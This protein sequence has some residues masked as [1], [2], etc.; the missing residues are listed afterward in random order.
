MSVD[1]TYLVEVGALTFSENNGVQGSWVHALPLGSY[2]HPVYG[3][4]DITPERA[5]NFEESVK[6]KVRG[7]DPSINYQHQ[8]D[9]E[10]AGWVKNAESRSD[11]L[12]LFVEWTSMAYQKLKEKAFKYFS[13]EYHDEWKDSQDKVHKD[14][15]FGGALTNR[16]FMKDLVPINLSEATVDTALE[17]VSII[18]GT[19]VED[20]KGGKGVPQELSDEQIK[21]IVDAVAEKVNPKPVTPEVS[22]T[23][24]SDIPEIKELAENNPFVKVLLDQVEQQRAAIDHSQVQL[25]EQTVVSKL[26]EFDRSKI[27]LTPV[28][29]ELVRDLAMG[30]SEAQSES[31][32]KLL[33][34]MRKGSSFLVE[35]GER[36]GA[37]VNYGSP[38]SAKVQFE[39]LAAKLKEERKLSESDSFEAAAAENRAL[40]DRYRAELMNGSGVN[41]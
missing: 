4:I 12:W 14:I 34:E 6:S 35:L 28:A 19:S 25:K 2:K 29:R 15:I 7:I 41:R 11:G 36:A 24:L 18:S 30:L 8:G 17:L 26:S 27:V 20:L 37:T 13:V 38:K 5:K 31:F 22:A 23:K 10:A 16:P 9:G 1:A 33:A 32:W 21:K 3:T 39:E 40:Y